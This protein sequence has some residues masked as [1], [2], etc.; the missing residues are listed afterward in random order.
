VSNSRA[1]LDISFSSNAEL[2]A[3]SYIISVTR[4]IDRTLSS[5]KQ[6]VF[7]IYP[8]FFSL[9]LDLA[10]LY[11]LPQPV[12][13]WNFSCHILLRLLHNYIEH[14]PRRVKHPKTLM[15]N[16]WVFIMRL[17]GLWKSLHSLQSLL[18]LIRVI[19]KL[20][21]CLLM[22]CVLYWCYMKMRKHTT[23]H[24]GMLF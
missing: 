12:T 18:T 23:C 13:H 17:I 9:S 21:Y 24:F 15:Y 11:F 4:T 16:N 1:H 19:Y 5:S 8:V 2:V 20:R 3:R 22:Y 6:N 10:L 7:L 14:W